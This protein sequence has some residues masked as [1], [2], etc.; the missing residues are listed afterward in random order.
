MGQASAPPPAGTQIAECQPPGGAQGA[1]A[2]PPLPANSTDQLWD[3]L[4][5]FS[6]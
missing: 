3:D 4:Q 6:P 2:D 1:R 5:F